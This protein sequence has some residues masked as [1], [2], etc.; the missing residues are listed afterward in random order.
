MTRI[1][2]G[3]GSNVERDRHI[4]SA[5]RMLTDAF[6][7]LVLSSVYESPAYGFA[8]DDFYNLVAG[9]DAEIELPSLLARLHDIEHACGRQ[10]HEGKFQ[11]R[12]LD[13]DLLVFGDL[14]HHDDEYDLPRQDIVRYAFVL[15]PLAEIAAT[16]RHPEL[17]KSYG[18]L[19]RDFCGETGP[20]RPV[21]I[22]LEDD[23]DC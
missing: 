17:G 7:R 4:R 22:S 21:R 12:S 13:L 16:E 9:F 10:R 19:W 1:Y 5:V 3:I 20:V 8:G 15:C 6:G 18:E 11:A 14:I 2:V 23:Q